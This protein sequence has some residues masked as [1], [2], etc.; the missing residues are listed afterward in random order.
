MSDSELQ[1]EKQR[2]ESVQWEICGEVRS[3]R[4]PASA[5]SRP[6]TVPN[7]EVPAMDR[8]YD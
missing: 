7:R 5:E 3:R 1:L 2:A 6:A 4:L 8:I